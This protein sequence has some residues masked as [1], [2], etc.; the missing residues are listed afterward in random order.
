ML[1][2][3]GNTMVI[4][5]NVNG[6]SPT[7]ARIVAGTRG[8]YAV[9]DLM[10]DFSSEWDG[11]IKKV[12]FYPVRGTPVYRVYTHGELTIPARVM[13]YDGVSLMTVSGYSVRADGKIDRKIITTEVDIEVE[14]TPSDTLYEPE[15]PDATTFE[16]IVDKLGAPYIGGNGNWFI[17]DTVTH[18]FK[19][20]GLPSRG[21]QGEVGRGLTVIGRFDTEEQLRVAVTNPSYGDAY[22]I[23]TK[24]PYTILIFDWVTDDWRDHG[25]LKGVGVENVEQI[26]S[27]TE[28]G[29]ENVVRLHMDNG[30][31][32][33]FVVRNGERG[34]RGVPGNIHMGESQPPAD[35]Y[36]WIDPE[37]TGDDILRVRVG[38]SFVSIPAIKGDKGEK[39]DAFTYADFTAEQLEA[40]KG[41]KGDPFTFSDF[42][43][44]ELDGLKGEKGDKG[45]TPERGKD[46]WTPD[47][48]NA[49]HAFIE[50][51]IINGVW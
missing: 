23:G 1:N 22:A 2:E 7:P 9:T 21:I 32:Y 15:I 14:A 31:Y 35:A 37:G 40:L 3:R 42:T 44:G 33:D 28:S 25:V 10:F 12:V 11:L 4:T 6:E 46:Y 24:L 26:T 18:E 41:A 49:I 30:D 39:G 45:Y 5:I 47:D 29:G 17:W 16:E 34:E 38:N 43:P 27:P 8:S 13:K 19:D 20:T 48:I 51:Q 50:E 36:I